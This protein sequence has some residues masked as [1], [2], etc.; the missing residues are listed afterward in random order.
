[1][2]LTA[3]AGAETPPE[4]RD[5][6]ILFTS[7]VHCGVDQGWGYAGLYDMRE[8]LSETYNVLLVDNGDA[9][10]GEPEK[11]TLT[12]C[13]DGVIVRSDI[14]SI[15]LCR[16]PGNR[17]REKGKNAERICGTDQ[18]TAGGDHRGLPQAL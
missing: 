13:H 16:K 2:G 7:D 6:I 17:D 9:T 4:E 12:R 14:V 8:K 3:E 5:L 11:K 10:Q 1:M 15:L 18:R